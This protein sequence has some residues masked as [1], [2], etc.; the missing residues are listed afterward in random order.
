MKKLVLIFAVLL[1][2]SSCVDQQ[3]SEV[4]FTMINETDKNVEILA[5]DIMDAHTGIYDMPIAADPIQIAPNSSYKI[6]R[7]TGIDDD[8]SYRF[9]SIQGIDSVRLIFNSE[10]SK[11]YNLAEAVGTPAI[12]VF[13]GNE[14]NQHIITEEDYNTAQDCDPDCETIE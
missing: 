4:I 11:V 8:V 7:Y 13:R 9:Y 5:F 10:K 2:L 12:S 14:N 3:S 6:T 1:T